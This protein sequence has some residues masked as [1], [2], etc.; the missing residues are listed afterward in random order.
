MDVDIENDIYI[1]ATKAM[2]IIKTT[3]TEEK[4]VFFFKFQHQL[5]PKNICGKQNWMS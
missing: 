3:A 5:M 2:T 1:K 4:D